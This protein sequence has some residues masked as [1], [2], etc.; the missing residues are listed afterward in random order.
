MDPLD[1]KTNRKL[2]PCTEIFSGTKLDDSCV[3]F[4]SRSVVWILAIMIFFIADRL[5]GSLFQ[6]YF[7]GVSKLNKKVMDRC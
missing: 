7:T 1:E 4:L 5:N 2:K 3:C 6:K